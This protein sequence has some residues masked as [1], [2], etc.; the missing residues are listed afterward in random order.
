MSIREFAKVVGVNPGMVVVQL[1]R[2]GLLPHSYCNDL[3][4]RYNWEKH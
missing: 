4:V 1:Q 2:K 3:K